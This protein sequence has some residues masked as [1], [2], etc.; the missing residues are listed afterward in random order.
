MK[1]IDNIEIIERN[2]LTDS[3]GYFVKVLTGKEKGL[4]SYTGEI[5]ITTAYPK[6]S[7]GG[8]YHKMATEWFTIIKGEALLCLVDV[9]TMERIDLHLSGS[10]HTTIKVPP[11]IAHA[12]YN[13]FSEE[14]MLLA[15]ND[16]FYDAKDTIPFEII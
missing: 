16:I 14:F 8:H 13:S 6:E 9:E 2:L 4:P 7:R 12:F 11:G 5:Y 15:Y 1:L 10:K 3:R